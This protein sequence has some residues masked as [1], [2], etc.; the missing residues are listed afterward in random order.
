MAGIEEIAAIILDK[1]NMSAYL[2]NKL[3]DR[4][5]DLDDEGRKKSNLDVEVLLGIDESGRLYFEAKAGTASLG[6]K[7]L[8]YDFTRR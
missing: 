1:S 4:L 7:L 8:R 2:Q 5:R 3:I 6:K